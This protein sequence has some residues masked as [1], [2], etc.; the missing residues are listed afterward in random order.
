MEQDINSTILARLDRIERLQELAVKTVLTVKE[1]CTLT[2]LSESRI[3]ALCSNRDIPHYKQGKTYF[4]RKEV[5]D[6]MT[7]NRVSTKMETASKAALYCHTH[8]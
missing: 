4:K 2:G 5:E 8:Q 1:V 7:A 6:W 3:H